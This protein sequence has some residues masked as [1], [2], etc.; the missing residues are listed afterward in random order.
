VLENVVL[1]PD[2]DVQLQLDYLAAK[3]QGKQGHKGMEGND[4]IRRRQQPRLIT[5]SR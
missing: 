2:R 4:E 1:T 5:S 3:H